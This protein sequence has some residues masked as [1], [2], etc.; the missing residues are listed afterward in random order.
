MAYHNLYDRVLV[1]CGAIK[2]TPDTHRLGL[3]GHGILS[4]LSELQSPRGAIGVASIWLFLIDVD[5]EKSTYRLPS[6]LG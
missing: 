4:D 3:T 5:D 1:I 6:N 2:V